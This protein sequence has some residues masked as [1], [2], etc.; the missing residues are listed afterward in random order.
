MRDFPTLGTFGAGGASL[1]T[2]RKLEAIVGRDQCTLSGHAITVCQRQLHVLGSEPLQTVPAP[3]PGELCPMR[4]EICRRC[5]RPFNARRSDKAYCSDRCR[6]LDWHDRSKSPRR[7]YYC[8]ATADNTDHIPPQSARRRIIDL[9]LSLKFPEIEVPCCSECN[10]LL[11]AR[12]LWTPALR[13]RF[14]KSALAKKYARFLKL[15]SWTDSELAQLGANLQQAT[16]A[17]LLM[18]EMVEERIKW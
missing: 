15:P 17:A 12:A 16:L 1:F 2:M 9:G 5:F 10:S 8:G 18:R 4:R 3:I 7:C 6:Y 11:G 13:K 14:I